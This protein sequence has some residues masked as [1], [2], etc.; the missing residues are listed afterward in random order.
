MGLTTEIQPQ[1]LWLCWW[2]GFSH[3]KI[4]SQFQPKVLKMPQKKKS[5]LA[6]HRV[7]SAT[8]SKLKN[9][10]R[11]NFTS[12][13]ITASQLRPKSQTNLNLVIRPEPHL[14]TELAIAITCLA[15]T[16]T[17]LLVQQT[18][19]LTFKCNLGYNITW[20]SHCV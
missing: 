7:R 1:I 11:P 2:V 16:T 3:Q 10:R 9:T 5:F 18:C 13:H 14:P 8:F 20:P 12:H 6:I 4:L 19:S 15:W 17:S